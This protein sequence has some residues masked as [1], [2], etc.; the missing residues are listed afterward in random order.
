MAGTKDGT[1]QCDGLSMALGQRAK[2]LSGRVTDRAC[3]GAW[4]EICGRGDTGYVCRHGECQVMWHH[5][6]PKVIQGRCS[7]ALG[8]FDGTIAAHLGG[9]MA[10]GGVPPP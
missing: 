2:S 9:A 10:Q 3:L 5:S 8:E 6:A 4:F 1:H 7:D